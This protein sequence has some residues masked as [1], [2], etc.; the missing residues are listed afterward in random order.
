[1]K[2]VLNKDQSANQISE[3][4]EEFNHFIQKELQDII[5]M[6]KL[7]QEWPALSPKMEFVIR[8]ISDYPNPIDWTVT[9]RNLR[10]DKQ[11]LRRYLTSKY[12]SRF[13]SKMIGLFDLSMPVDYRLFCKQV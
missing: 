3:V 11:K 13:A 7:D 8:S 12:S 6:E 4:S 9:I 1:M 2:K 10:I 5:L